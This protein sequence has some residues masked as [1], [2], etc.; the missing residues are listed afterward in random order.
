MP[1]AAPQAPNWERS[2]P[3]TA[4]WGSCRT[5][6]HLRGD[7]S[8]A[9]YPDRIP[10]VIASGEVDHLVVRPGQVGDTVFEP[11]PVS[12]AGDDR[13]PAAAGRT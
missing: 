11:R 12:A 8:C 9:A 6:R 7:M 13:S 5:C 1:N 10:L 2:V 3:L 4:R